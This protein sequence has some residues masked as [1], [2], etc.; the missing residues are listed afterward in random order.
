[1]IGEII[2][3]KSKVKFL[4]SSFLAEWMSACLCMWVMDLIL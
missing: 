1:M 2:K 3:K 4:W